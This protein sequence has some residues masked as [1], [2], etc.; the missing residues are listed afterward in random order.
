MNKELKNI[1]PWHIALTKG[2]I[3]L[4]KADPQ[5]ADE[6]VESLPK[7]DRKIFHAYLEQVIKYQEKHN[8]SI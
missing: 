2:F 4:C 8:W 7:K 1:K 6:M 5:L 3:A